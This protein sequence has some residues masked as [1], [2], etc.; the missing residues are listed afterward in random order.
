MRKLKQKRKYKTLVY[1]V[2][3]HLG[4]ICDPPRHSDHDFCLFV[5]QDANVFINIYTEELFGIF[6]S[7]I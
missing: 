3:V 6:K 1:V 2:H 7:K 4:D 5:H